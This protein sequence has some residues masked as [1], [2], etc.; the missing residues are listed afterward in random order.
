[1]MTSNKK[2]FKISAVNVRIPESGMV[3]GQP[4][5][6]QTYLRLLMVH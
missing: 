6:K 3:T 4:F 1:M 5:E 2:L